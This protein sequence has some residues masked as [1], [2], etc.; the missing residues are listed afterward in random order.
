[1]QKFKTLFSASSSK[2]ILFPL[3]YALG[4]NG[5]M[6]SAEK[7][8][9][10]LLCFLGPVKVCQKTVNGRRRNALFGLLAPPR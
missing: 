3:F 7:V 5:F 8:L 1:M 6:P 4:S 2:D 9:V 10:G